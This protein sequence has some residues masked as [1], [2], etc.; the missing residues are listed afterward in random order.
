M[1]RNP[2]RSPRVLTLNLSQEDELSFDDKDKDSRDIKI[3]VL[4]EKIENSEE[5]IFDSYL[6]TQ[7]LKINGLSKKNL[8]G[9]FSKSTRDYIKIQ[10]LTEMIALISKKFLKES[11][12]KSLEVVLQEKDMN[13]KFFTSP[14]HQHSLEFCIVDIFN[15]FL[16]ANESSDEFYTKVLPGYLT[17]EFNII[18]QLNLKSQISIPNLFVIMQHYNKIYFNDNLDINFDDQTPFV[19]QDIK[20]ISPYYI[21][22]WFS[23]ASSKKMSIKENLFNRGADPSTATTNVK[24]IKNFNFEAKESLRRF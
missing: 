11:V 13:K 15:T 18:I 7:L 20:Y 8:G 14:T 19:A 12:Q 17:E 10:L 5:Y 9:L 4:T 3:S 2:I 1:N 23:F 21:N 22:K 6:L 16:G 24:R